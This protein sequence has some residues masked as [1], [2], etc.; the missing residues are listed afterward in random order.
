MKKWKCEV[1]YGTTESEVCPESCPRCHAPGARLTEVSAGTA[2]TAKDPAFDTLASM[3]AALSRAATAKTSTSAPAPA[4]TPAPTPAPAPAATEEEEPQ[5]VKA[6]EGE[7]PYIFISY[8]HKNSE[9]VMPIIERLVADGYRVWYDEGIVP[10]SEWDEFIASHIKACGCV[11]SMISKEY[12]E[13]DNC[14][15]ELKYARDK[16]KP[17]L[18]IYLT[19]TTLTEGMQM[20]LNRIQAVFK[21]AYAYEEGFYKKLYEADLMDCCTDT[22]PQRVSVTGA[23][24]GTTTVPAKKPAA[25]TSSTLSGKTHSTGTTGT[26]SRTATPSEADITILKRQKSRLVTNIK[27]RKSVLQTQKAEFTKKQRAS[28]ACAVGYFGVLFLLLITGFTPYGFS[29]FLATVCGLVSAILS[30]LEILRHRGSKFGIVKYLL[31]GFVNSYILGIYGIYCCLKNIKRPKP[32]F[33]TDAE[34]IALQEELTYV[35]AQLG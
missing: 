19:P 28:W 18:L 8:A 35:E 10:G 32:D 13:S 9:E 31:W 15:D 21:Y 11:V 1:C 7:Q 24:T 14:K 29:A 23:T 4:P 27:N 30:P 26:T 17:Q 22:P 2:E 6:Y 3:R 20:R 25:S 12:M 33:E 5:K 16:D 34:L